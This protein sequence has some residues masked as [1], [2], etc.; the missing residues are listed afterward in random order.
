MPDPWKK[1][2]FP[3]CLACPNTAFGCSEMLRVSC[4]RF[5]QR[6]PSPSAAAESSS[7]ILALHYA[8]C[9]GPGTWT[10]RLVTSMQ[11]L[12]LMRRIDYPWPSLTPRHA[13][14]ESWMMRLWM[15]A[16]S[17]PANSSWGLSFRSA[18]LPGADVPQPI[19]YVSVQD[20]SLFRKK[21]MLFHQ[22]WVCV[23]FCPYSLIYAGL[24]SSGN[25]GFWQQTIF[26]WSFLLEPFFV[27]LTSILP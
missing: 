21:N 11:S 14:R 2:S 17:L 19:A 27:F 3:T 25:T 22:S 9:P 6:H 12:P 1:T 16:C 15:A 26:Y 5:P 7:C 13:P 18:A 20:A 23:I 4:Q 24:S 8:A 10:R